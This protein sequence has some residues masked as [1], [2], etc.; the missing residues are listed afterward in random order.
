MPRLNVVVAGRVPSVVTG[1]EDEV[2]VVGELSA[3]DIAEATFCARA[4]AAVASLNTQIAAPR[5]AVDVRLHDV[6]SLEPISPHG[7]PSQRRR[8]SLLLAVRRRGR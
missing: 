3:V 1:E 5:S 4:L 8:S 7:Y 6:R 2:G